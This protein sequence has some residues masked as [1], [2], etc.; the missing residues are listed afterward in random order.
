[1]LVLISATF[2]QADPALLIP[3][4]DVCITNCQL[5]PASQ[6]QHRLLRVCT[7]GLT[8]YAVLLQHK[9]Q[10]AGHL[11]VREALQCSLDEAV[12]FKEAAEAELAKVCLVSVALEHVHNCM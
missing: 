5:T 2:T 4:A 1:M 9:L 6:S 11:Q 3:R 12:I 8:Y 7:R 10:A